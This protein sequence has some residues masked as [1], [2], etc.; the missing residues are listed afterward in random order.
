V[1]QAAAF[2]LHDSLQHFGFGAEG[3]PETLEAMERG[4]NESLSLDT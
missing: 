4:E 1:G 2:Q 3:F